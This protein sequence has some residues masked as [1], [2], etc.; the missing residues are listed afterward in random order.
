M[1][2]KITYLI[3]K[4]VRFTKFIYFLIIINVVVLILESFK[5]LE[6]SFGTLF[7]AIE[8]F[9]VIIF[10]IEYLLRIWVAENKLKFIFSTYGII[11]LLA[12]L[13][14]YLPFMLTIDL[15]VLRLLRLLRLVRVFK[16]ARYSNS[17][18]LIGSVF[19]ENQSELLVTLFITFILLVISSTLMFHIEHEAQPDK[20]ENIGQ[21]FWWAI[22]TLTTVGYGD[23]YPI[24]ALGKFLSA[25]IAIIGIGFIALPTGV[26]CSSFIEKLQESRKS[27]QQCECPKCG[28]VFEK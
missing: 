16:L 13:P 3:N 15:R 19:K 4:D 10:T 12:I 26:I 23:I 22:A 14:F 28:N 27:K 7:Y 8:V 6:E 5:S 24:T 2:E 17:L 20:F 11:D 9:S 18:K 21:S 25:V 1:K